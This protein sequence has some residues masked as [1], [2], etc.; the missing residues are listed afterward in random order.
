MSTP[1]WLRPLIGSWKIKFIG[2]PDVY[3]LVAVTADDGELENKHYLLSGDVYALVAATANGELENKLIRSPVM[4][5]PLL[6]AT[7]DHGELENK[8]YLLACDVY[9]LVAA[10]ADHGKLGQKKIIRL[11]AMSTP[12]WL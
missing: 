2:S 4:S 3:A 11:P 1:L 5:T 6:A 7:A 8:N 10:T 12:L 9:A